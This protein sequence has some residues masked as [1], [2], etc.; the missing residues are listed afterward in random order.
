MFDCHSAKGMTK[1]SL[2][3][4]ISAFSRFN[5]RRMSI[6]GNC[7]ETLHYRY[8]ARNEYGSITTAQG[9]AWKSYS[10][11]PHYLLSSWHASTPAIWQL[12]Q[13][14]TDVDSKIATIILV[15]N[16]IYVSLCIL[17][18]VSDLSTTVIVRYLRDCKLS[19]V[20]TLYHVNRIE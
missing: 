18:G 12:F 7:S 17:I 3:P 10:C 11:M 1:S 19:T 4:W 6:R 9:T 15:E 13:N 16:S 2:K 14:C 5:Q 8:L 20:L